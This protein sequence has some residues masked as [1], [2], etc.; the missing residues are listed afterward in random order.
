MVLRS[1]KPIYA[2]ME[3][4]IPMKLADTIQCERRLKALESEIAQGRDAWKSAGAALI[5]IRDDKLFEFAGYETF[6]AYCEQK[7]GWKKRNAN[8]VIASYEAFKSLPEQAGKILPSASQARELAKVPEPK[9]ADVL[10]AAV[11]KAARR[12]KP[13]TAASIKEA[14]EESEVDAD[15]VTQAEIQTAGGT[16]SDPSRPVFH[17]RLDA[18]IDAVEA[19][20]FDLQAFRDGTEQFTP[21]GAEDVADAL[22]TAAA[23]II[24][25]GKRMKKF[26]Q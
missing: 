24:S 3:G 12:G 16:D 5:E 25:E 19:A 1:A 13:L 23:A 22:R 2:D 10:E 15:E 7:W 17:P 18:I 9:R 11:T 4:D 14:A 20:A 21:G 26:E 8:T 6:W